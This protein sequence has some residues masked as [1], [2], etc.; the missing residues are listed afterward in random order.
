VTP[1]ERERVAFMYRR[2][3]EAESAP[4]VELPDLVREARDMAWD[5]L[6]LEPPRPSDLPLVGLRSPTGRETDER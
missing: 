1:D 4:L 6:Q 3:R 5:A 2:L